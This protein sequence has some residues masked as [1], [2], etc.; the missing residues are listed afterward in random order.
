MKKLYLALLFF[1]LIIFSFANSV[2]TAAVSNG[3]WKINS[4]WNLNRVPANGDTVVIPAGKIVVIDNVQN[5][6]NSFLYIEVYGTLKITDGKLWLDVNS[7]I[8][9]FLGG[10]IIGTGNSSETLRINGVNKFWGH[11]D[12]TILGPAYAN[13]ATGISPNGF[14][15]GN[16][17][18]PVKFIGFSLTPEKNNIV[19]E[20]ATA[21]E[22][23]S[24]YYEVQRSDDG[25]NW[26]TVAKITAAGNSSLTHSYSYTDQSFT[27][28]SVFYRIRQVDI[29]GSFAYTVV[30]M[31]KNE[32]SKA[33][34]NL[35][36]VSNSLYIHFSE[37]EKN[38][39]V[40]LTSFN[41]QLISQT[42]LNEAIGQV[43]MPVQKNVRGIY[44]VTITDGETL[45]YSKQIFL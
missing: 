24:S 16:I 28:P 34:I 14:V 4:T 29:D 10:A 45:K 33:N 2:I 13:S 11:N 32:S 7:S 40:R 8:V 17:A 39:S 18:L 38:V 15:L 30:R 12:V 35:S 1:F 23:N 25:N 22:I 27:S 26:K 5:L 41:G 31:L 19:V 43:V 37:K 3:N 20:W 42:M 6:S 36:A 21:E 9:V 44:V